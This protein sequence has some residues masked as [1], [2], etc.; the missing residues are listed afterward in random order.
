MED[1]EP[2]HFPMKTPGQL[3]TKINNLLR[4]VLLIQ[5]PGRRLLGPHWRPN[6]ISE[7][8][9][10]WATLDLGMDQA[11]QLCV[12]AANQHP[13][14]IPTAEDNNTL[15]WHGKIR[16]VWGPYRRPSGPSSSVKF[17]N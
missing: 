11:E 14:G 8:I 13:S 10:Q 3:S 1:R 2:G 16:S 17:T 7:Q 4:S 9:R 15:K 6:P 5:V 12:D